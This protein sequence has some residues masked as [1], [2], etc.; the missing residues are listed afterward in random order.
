MKDTDPFVFS[1]EEIREKGGLKAVLTPDTAQFADV[2]EKPGELKN[3]E[4]SLEFIPEEKG[5]TI[6]AG[7]LAAELKLECHR[8]AGAFTSRYKENFDEVY[9]DTVEYPDVREAVRDT[10][11]LLVPMKILCS[12]ACKGLCPVC[13]MNRNIAECSCRP[14]ENRPFTALDALTDRQTPDKN[15]AR[16]KRS[17][18]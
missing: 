17:K 3:L 6:L 13:G 5:A 10:L 1:R 2:L 7:S 18:E 4:L 16:N 8:C 15:E 14:P 12:D 9:E 11:A